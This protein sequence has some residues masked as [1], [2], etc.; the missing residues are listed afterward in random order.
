MSHKSSQYESLGDFLDNVPYCM[1]EVK[2]NEW[3]FGEGYSST[4]GFETTQEIVPKFQLKQGDRVLDVGCGVGGHDFYMAE[5][6]GAIIDAVDLSKN[7]MSV[8][9]DH[10]RKK[11]HLA[12]KIN[13]RLCDVTNTDFPE[14]YYDVIYSREVFVHNSDKDS[15]FE[16]FFKWL[17]PGGRLMFTD[18][19]CGNKEHSEE[20]KKYIA[21]RGYHLLTVQQYEE[22]MNRV[23]FVNVE[24]EDRSHRFV[25]ALQHELKKLYDHKEDFLQ[26]FNIEVFN[27]LAEGWLAKC[28]RAKDGDQTWAFCYGE[29]PN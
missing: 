29:K 21:K 1:Q 25:D 22:L 11:P 19:S 17:K 8:A 2:K 13:F 5:K 23:G 15:L 4:G 18:Y 14:G 9:L 10:F 12:G 27:N 16:K 24:A 26:K 7:M 20:F 3:I 28:R 6:Y